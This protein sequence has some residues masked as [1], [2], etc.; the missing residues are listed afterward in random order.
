[1]ISHETRFFRITHATD[2]ETHFEVQ[3][4]GQTRKPDGSFFNP[5][6]DKTKETIKKVTSSDAFQS[7][8]KARTA[9]KKRLPSAAK[10]VSSM[11][12]LAIPDFLSP[13]P[14]GAA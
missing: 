10:K 11:P 6:Q 12:L 2:P 4:R 14:S 5:V 8:S 3:R 1:L 13:C 9:L 7:S